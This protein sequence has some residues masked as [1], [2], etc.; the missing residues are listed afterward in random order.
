M[1]Y[2]PQQIDAMSLWEFAACVDG[3]VRSKGVKEDAAAPSA[4]EHEAM[5]KKMNGLIG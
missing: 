2:T 1:R 4:E 5:L 3:F